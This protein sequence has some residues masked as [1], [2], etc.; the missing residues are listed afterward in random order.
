[1]TKPNWW[2]WEVTPGNVISWVTSLIAIVTVIVWLQADVKALKAEGDRQDR[3]M[4]KIEERQ[5]RASES[6][7]DM[8][9]DIKVIRQILESTRGR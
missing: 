9:G 4:T 3:R 6:I 1:M 5:E 2:K 7:A 8:K